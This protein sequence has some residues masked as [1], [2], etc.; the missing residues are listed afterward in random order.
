M[1]SETPSA[2]I[3]QS[4]AK[5]AKKSS[6]PKVK[7]KASRRTSSVK[8]TAKGSPSAFDSYSQ[9]AQEFFNRS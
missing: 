9:Q 3:N 6:A 4:K 7:A 5:G 2:G 1:K 8:R